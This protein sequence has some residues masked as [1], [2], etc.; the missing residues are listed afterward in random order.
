MRHLTPKYATETVPSGG[1]PYPGSVDGRSASNDSVK[2]ASLEA[3]MGHFFF[4]VL[5]KKRPVMGDVPK[6]GINL[7]HFRQVR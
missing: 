3:R 5:P 1:N 7:S 6:S 2:R 4:G